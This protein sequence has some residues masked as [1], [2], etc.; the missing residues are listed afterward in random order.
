MLVGFNVR[1]L[2]VYGATTRE[3]EAVAPPVE[4]VMTAVVLTATDVVATINVA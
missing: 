2:T 3:A 1:L 4:A